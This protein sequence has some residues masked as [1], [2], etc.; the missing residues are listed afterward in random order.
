VPFSEI[1]IQARITPSRAS[2]G[3]PVRDGKAGCI[4]GLGERRRALERFLIAT[5]EEFLD[6]FGT[7]DLTVE[8]EHVGGGALAR[9]CQLEQL[10]SLCRPRAPN[11]VVERAALKPFALGQVATGVCS[12]KQ[13]GKALVAREGRL[14]RNTRNIALSVPKATGSA[15]AVRV[16][17]CG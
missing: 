5:G 3:R 15:T 8:P 4:D 13:S 11:K 6:R 16:G 12:L 7:L 10:V 14:I 17:C 1:S 2:R 9:C